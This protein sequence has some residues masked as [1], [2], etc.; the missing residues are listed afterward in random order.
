[1]G[2]GGTREHPAQ[3]HPDDAARELAQERVGAAMRV[4]GRW[5]P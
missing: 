5:P 2:K 4:K 1:M 3:R